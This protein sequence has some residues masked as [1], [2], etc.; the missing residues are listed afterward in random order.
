MTSRPQKINRPTGAHVELEL[1]K[2]L[3][4]EYRKMPKEMK[5]Q[6]DKIFTELSESPKYRDAWISKFNHATAMG[7]R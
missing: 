1:K 2:Q 6:F 5:T 3:E 7:P 4:I